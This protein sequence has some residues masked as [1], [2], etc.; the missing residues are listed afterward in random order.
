[1]RK[2]EAGVRLRRW[3]ACLAV[4]AA[5]LCVV[6]SHPG[7]A[8]PAQANAIQ[9]TRAQ[10]SWTTYLRSGPGLQFAVIDEVESRSNVDVVGCRDG[11]CLVV[12]G[13]AEG[14]LAQ[15]VLPSSTPPNKTGPSPHPGDCFD[16]HLKGYPKGGED[17]RFCG[18]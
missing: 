2:N 11:W 15:S 1:M 12:Y 8:S 9:T 5:G 10:T 16:A 3:P 13:G 14:Y 17:V 18:Q 6:L 4:A 7:Q